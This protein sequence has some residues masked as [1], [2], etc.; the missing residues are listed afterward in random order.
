[1]EAP[2]GGREMRSILL[3]LAAS[4][5]M[6]GLL[7]CLALRAARELLELNVPDRLGPP[8]RSPW[9]RGLAHA[10]PAAAWS[11]WAVFLGALAVL[12]GLTLMGYVSLA[13]EQESLKDFFALWRERFT[14]AGDAP[15]YLWLAEHGYASAGDNVNLIVFYP[16]YPFLTG[17]LGRLLGGRYVL[18]A[19]LISQFSF[20]FASVLLWRG[21]VLDTP[22]PGWAMWAFWLYPFGLFALGVFTEG[23]FL[24]LS[25]GCLYALR[26][27]KWAW[28]GLCGAL[29][30]L[31][32]TQG[33]ALL[34][35]YVYAAWRAA[36]S[37]GFRK[38][39]LCGAA[40]P[41]GW[42]VYLLLNRLFAGS[43][44]AF[45]VYESL[46]PWFQTTQWIGRTIA[47]QAD[48]ALAYP[49]LGTI[50]YWPQLLL[51][52][53]AAALLFAALRNRLPTEHAVYGTAYLGI[54]YL[55]GWLI[56][57]G[58]YLFGCTP[59]FLSA[60]CFRRRWGVRLLLAAEALACL[61][62]YRN[63]MAGESIM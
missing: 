53:A 55:A 58:R 6:A 27:E 9:R 34:P 10:H 48:M 19:L 56:S 31:T 45:R 5:T 60:G 38:T 2:E 18:S 40:I 39:M 26:R 13:R 47:Q 43:W 52:F 49:W 17:L 62:I 30:M 24:L 50:I 44:F 29:A 7:A 54:C 63:F 35:A 46:S 15:H 42:G 32:R 22:R 59:L 16:L 3:N 8:R 12:W 11:G 36:R 28:A 61:W 37:G 51:Y 1:M 41:A 14:T 20:G 4:L 25:V 23:L 57:G 21:A 33:M